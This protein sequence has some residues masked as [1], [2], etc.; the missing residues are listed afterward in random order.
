[1]ADLSCLFEKEPTTIAAIDAWYEAKDS[2]RS[3]LGL[4]QAGHKCPRFLWYR[5]NGYKGK[6]IEGRVLRLFQL[7]N[8]LEEQVIIDLK[9]IGIHHHSSQKEVTFTQ[10]D[11]KL[12]GH[13]DGIV[14]GL[15][16]SP[17]TPHL[18]ENKSASKKKFEEL[19]KL[20]SYQKFNETYYWQIQFYMLGLKLTR[21]AVF[22]YNKDNSSLYMERIRLDKEATIA[23]LQMVFDAIS[24]DIPDRIQN[25]AD[26][27]ECKWCDFHKECFK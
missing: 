6:P 19:V 15:V 14:E 11:L 26:N 23:K 16:E 24:G 22:V 8:V 12:T 1:M 7:G 3:W 10:G 21:A 5:H 25:R 27:F 2:Q 4:S 9:S 18:F 17:A 13:I 20:N